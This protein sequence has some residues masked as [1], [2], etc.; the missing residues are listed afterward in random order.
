MQKCFERIADGA[1]LITANRG[2]SRRLAA[3]Y[4]EY[5]LAKGDEAWQTPDILPYNAWLARL[6]QN[7]S[8]PAD[9]LAA[10]RAGL[11]L[12]DDL[13]ERLVWESIISDSDA[14]A[15]LLDVYE[16]ARMARE[17]WRLCRQWGVEIGGGIE[18]S[19]PDP[20][21]FAG[22]ADAFYQF[23]RESGFIDRESLAPY[24]AEKAAEGS[25]GEVPDLILAGFDEFFPALQE[26]L[27]AVGSRGTGIFRLAMPKRAGCARLAVLEDDE[28]EIRAA[29]RWARNRVESDPAAR[30]GVVS[31][32]LA[33]DRQAVC[34]AFDDVFHPSAVFSGQAPERRMFQIS[35]AP[36][37]SAYPVV[38]AA[39]A[40]LELTGRQGAD[41]DQWSRLLL[42][43]FTKGAETE[44]ASR[45][46]LD[47]EIRARGDL[48]FTISRAAAV[49]RFIRKSSSGGTGPDIFSDICEKL[50]KHALEMPARQSPEKWADVFSA[51]L[52]AAGWPGERTLS[53]S[54]YQSVS[55]FQ[56]SMESLA[57]S[58]QVTGPVSYARA[59]RI[60]V[61]RLAETPF[62][63][64]QPDSG[65]RI[66]GMLES[67]GEEF[68]AL[69]IMGMHHELWP[70]PS[71]P[72]PFLPV[73]VQRRLGLPHSSPAR[74]LSYARQI[75]GRLLDSAD[76]IVCSFGAAD[77]ESRRLPSPL[78]DHLEENDMRDLVPEESGGYWQS[79]HCCGGIEEIADNTGTGLPEGAK[80]PGGTG[81]MKSQALCPF[82]AY[83]RYRL[84]ACSPETPEPGLT[85]RERG[86]LVHRVLELL[87]KRLEGHRALSEM[88]PEQIG[89]CI[90]EAVDAAVDR[91][92]EKMPETFTS[93][94]TSVESD[95]LRHLAGQWLEAERGRMPFE[96]SETE[97]RMQVNVGGIVLSALADRI[98]RLEDGRLVIIDYKTGTPSPK[99]WFA[100]RITEPQLP[101]YSLGLGEKNPAGVFFG[102]VRK[103]DLGYMGISDTEGLVPGVK[104][105]MD[106]GKV[107]KDFESMQEVLGWWEQKLSGLAAEIRTGRADVSPVSLN[108]AC[109]YCDLSALCRIWEVSEMQA[110]DTGSEHESSY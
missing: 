28:A 27:S 26:L 56:E 34:R 60:L 48:F 32:K 59:R 69:W 66:T 7:G 17:A 53:S 42:S 1:V 18:W 47:Y 96:V 41:V 98:D 36:M 45:A 50:Q 25:P 23:C 33:A 55:A 35:A 8:S 105:V 44:Y 91:L 95:R 20:A 97:S 85:P 9:P 24:L 62:Q 104:S 43:P 63:P 68:D 67:A 74:E 94:F 22:W 109:R 51:I 99:E 40:I 14:A 30:I 52:D 46:A 11:Q 106:D 92:A 86:T 6:F 110:E 58:G 89:A 65:V 72:S 21:A 103:G 82:Q 5:R 37:L 38:E 16:T 61:R 100:E 19:S 71:R 4:A 2:L 12:M 31:P 87:W 79:V 13:Q 108:L 10:G 102:R 70:T 49:A 78:I 83:G 73:P 3:R 101:I 54:E 90:R 93:R 57:K 107:A 77:G 80:V 29:A 81:I 88:G 39:C 64:E 75:T 76:E 84:G 15:G